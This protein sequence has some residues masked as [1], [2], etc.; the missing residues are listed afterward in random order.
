MPY[1]KIRPK[2]GTASQWSSANT[3][4]D[5]REIGF[6]YPSGGLG[7][8]LVKMKMGDG[9][10]P[11][12]SLPYA[13]VASNDY[14]ITDDL[15]NNLTSSA[16]NK[17]LAAAQGKALNDKITK[18]MYQLATSGEVD[19]GLKWIDGK[20]IYM[21]VFHT[22]ALSAGQ[23][24]NV[25]HNI[26]V[27]SFVN[28]ESSLSFAYLA[29]GNVFVNL[30]RSARNGNDA[31]EMRCTG[32]NGKITIVTGASAAFSDSYVTLIYTKA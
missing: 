8:G 7:K 2:A 16:T 10:T 9:V 1:Y 30:P 5:E 15:V 14:D 22:G 17:A 29:S 26:S 23:E 27:G 20:S 6:E 3:V 21:K 4:L 28:I 12:N 11:W 13:V 19:T 32:T 25:N 24:V 31:I 18:L